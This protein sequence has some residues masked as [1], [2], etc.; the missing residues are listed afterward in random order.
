MFTMPNNAARFCL[1]HV[2]GVINDEIR[3]RN[4]RETQNPNDKINAGVPRELDFGGSR[5]PRLIR[6]SEV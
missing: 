6:N 1:C 4:T 5:T 2:E 3:M